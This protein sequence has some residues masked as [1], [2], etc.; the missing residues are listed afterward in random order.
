MF[1]QSPHP[2]SP[3]SLCTPKFTYS[4]HTSFHSF[5]TYLSPLNLYFTSVHPTS[6]Y[7]IPLIFH[8]PRSTQS[9]RPSVYSA[10]SYFPHLSS[11]YLSPLIRHIPQSIQ[12]PHASIS[13][14]SPWHIYTITFMLENLYDSCPCGSWNCVGILPEAG[15]IMLKCPEMN[16]EKTPWTL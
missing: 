6:I 9:A 7:L 15:E 2:H 8:G 12:L 1:T 11:T 10:A 5:L 14:A 16:R 13:W 4:P 3:F